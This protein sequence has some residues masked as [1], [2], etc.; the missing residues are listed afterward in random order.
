MT[1]L[2][3]VTTNAVNFAIVNIQRMDTIQVASMPKLHIPI[4]WPS[5]ILSYIRNTR[6]PYGERLFS[7]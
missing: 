6:N 2:L 5:F 7:V 1:A 3:H 4:K